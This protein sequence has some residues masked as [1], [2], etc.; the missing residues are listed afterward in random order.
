MIVVETV[1]V[2]LG[3]LALVLVLSINGLVLSLLW[4]QMDTY[5]C[6][7]HCPLPLHYCM[8][9]QCSLHQPIAFIGLLAL[10]AMPMAVSRKTYFYSL[11]CPVSIGHLNSALYK[12]RLLLSG[13]LRPFFTI[14]YCNTKSFIST[15][16]ATNPYTLH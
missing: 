5:L 3:K 4:Q 10:I 6:Q 12:M 9:F 15:A 14:D 1:T 16:L 7:F 13:H 8:Q 11:Q 2:L